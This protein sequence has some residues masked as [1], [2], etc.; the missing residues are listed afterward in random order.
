MKIHLRDGNNEETLHEET[1][2]NG[3]AFPFL[4]VVAKLVIPLREGWKSC[5]LS[6]KNWLAK[7]ALNFQFENSRDI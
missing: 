5:R 7:Y 1:W 4:L 6:S 2:Y 3:A